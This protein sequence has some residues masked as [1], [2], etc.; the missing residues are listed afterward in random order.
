MPEISNVSIAID[1]KEVLQ[2]KTNLDAMANSADDAG[3]ELDDLGMSSQKA[4]NKIKGMVKPVKQSTVAL[5]Q[6]RA[7]A[8]KASKKT[9]R[10]GQIA[11]QAG[12]QVQDFAV[13]VQGG[14]SAL[15]AF[16]QQGS[17][18]AGAF[19]PTGAIIGAFIAVGAAVGGVLWS[20]F[21]KGGEA[22]DEY[23]VKVEDLEESFKDLNQ[24]Q[25][26]AGA[27]AARKELKNL[28]EQQ[29]ELNKIASE[30]FS[31]KR[32]WTD[33]MEFRE[34]LLNRHGKNW[35][36]F[37]VNDKKENDKRLLALDDYNEKLGAAE[38]LDKEILALKR[39]ISDAETNPQRQKAAERRLAGQKIINNNIEK[40]SAMNKQ[41]LAL[42]KEREKASIGIENSKRRTSKIEAAQLA[43]QAESKF[44]QFGAEDDKFLAGVIKSGQSEIEIIQT[45]YARLAEIHSTSDQQ[46]RDIRLAE[47]ALFSE[48]EMEKTRI[49]DEQQQLRNEKMEQRFS[50]AS[51]IMGAFQSLEGALFNSKRARLDDELR[52]S[53]ELSKKQIKLKEDEARQLFNN[54]KHANMAMIA[55]N[56]AGAVMSE[57]NKGGLVAA[58]AVGATGLAQLAAVNSTSYK[59]PVQASTPASAPT[60]EQSPQ[61]QQVQRHEFN[62]TSNIQNDASY[63]GSEVKSIIERLQDE[64]NNGGQMPA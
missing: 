18:L 55:I 30:A 31:S 28:T 6:N 50:D 57:Y 59:S 58:L 14:Q 23:R 2:A 13:Q 46:T 16:G 35:A 7:A 27:I 5:N 11:G 45:K 47:I 26:T 22:I 4:G 40:Q 36:D 12:F 29:V 63:A 39:L 64:L 51:N 61:Q 38:T 49:A 44:K 41:L 34:H 62:I 42:E 60:Q 10:F 56:T 1:T 9:G 3:E 54:Q 19:G 21:N 52:N 48:F 20:Q 43:R 53:G 17:Q 37:Y 15:L 33:E 8:A 32:V 24:V 25:L